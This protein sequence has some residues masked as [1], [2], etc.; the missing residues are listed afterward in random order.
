MRRRKGF[1]IACAV[2]LCAGAP[3][4]VASGQKGG[5]RQIAVETYVSS[6]AGARLTPQGVR[7]FGFT[8]KGYVKSAAIVVDDTTE[9]QKMVGFGASF[10]EA[11][12]IC[13][14]SLSAARRAEVLRALFDPQA[15]A[16]FSVMKSPIAA[17]DFMSAGPWYSYD[18]VPGDVAMA[19]FSIAR[20]LAPDGL[21]PY[22]K[23]ARQYGNFIIQSP[24]DYPPDW[25]LYDVNSHQDVN[26]VY[27][28]ALARYYVRYLKAYEE[29]GVHIDYLSLFNEPGIYTKIDYSAIAELIK[30]HVGPALAG[31]RTQLQ[32][33]EAPTRTV[34]NLYYPTVLDDPAA[35]AYVANVPYHGYETGGFD[36]VATLHERYPEFQL[37][38]TE[39]SGGNGPQYDFN[40]GAFWGEQIASDVEAGASAWL[41]WNMILDE[42]GGPWLVSPVHNDPVINNQ[43]PVVVINR[44]TGAV[45]Y[46]G[47]YYYLAHFSKF[48]RP[49]ATR[50]GVAGVPA[51]VRA[52]AF[53]NADG[54]FVTQLLN[55][56]PQDKQV[57]LAWRGHAL[58][59]T[60]P[61]V[62]ITTCLWR[63]P[64]LI[65]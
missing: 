2:I 34:A 12:Q 27:Y 63:A 26:P 10:N 5:A 11:G 36:A 15:G 57:T 58:T 23:S 33:S 8:L 14:N 29:N 44:Q 19:H 51:G 47:L 61:A 35:R 30:N 3:A 41:Y 54:Q 55:A 62:S 53:R 65:K 16:G 21:L 6:S 46:T 42:D 1:I 7:D 56:D 13:L 64:K 37:W 22:I 4:R 43:H 9:Y 50:I 38:M 17:T 45:T 39:L 18:D 28:D 24:M 31:T 59:L 52:L 49:E 40:N 48:V 32:L 25:M 60:L 20:D